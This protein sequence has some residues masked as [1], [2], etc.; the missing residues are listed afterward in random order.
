MGL[1]SHVDFTPLLASIGNLGTRDWMTGNLARI[2]GGRHDMISMLKYASAPGRPH[3]LYAT[4]EI[5]PD[6][7]DHNFNRSPTHVLGLRTEDTKLGVYSKWVPL[8]SHV[9]HPSIEVE[10]YDYSTTQGQLELDNTADSEPGTKGMVHH[11]LTDIVPNELQEILPGRL[12]FAQEAS[13]IAHLAFR[14]LIALKPSGDWKRGDLTN[15]LR[16]GAEF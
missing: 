6:I 2:Y 3:V 13:K 7:Y 10:F 16:Y 12:R 8:T 14:E 4:D 5:V 1:T 15:V 11:L 9:I